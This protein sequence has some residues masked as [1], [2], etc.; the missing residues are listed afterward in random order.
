MAELRFTR[1]AKWKEIHSPI[2]GAQAFA[3][4]AVRVIVGVEPVVGWHMSISTPYRNPTWEEIRQ[5]R[6]DLVPDEVTMAMLLPPKEEYI[7]VHSFCFHLYQVPEDVPM[8]FR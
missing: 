8:V 5:A 2:R 3:W 4:G 6:Y 1:R 7:N